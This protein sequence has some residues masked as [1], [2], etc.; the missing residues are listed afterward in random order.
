MR[1][2]SGILRSDDATI[3]PGVG[4]LRRSI[5]L[6]RDGRRSDFATGTGRG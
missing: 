3:S 2:A 6:V 4:R 1:H 5:R